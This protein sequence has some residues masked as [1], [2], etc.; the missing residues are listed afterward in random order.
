MNRLERSIDPLTA[1]SDNLRRRMYLY[2]R[3]EGH[4]VSRQEVARAAGVS[5]KLAAFHL[6]KLVEQ[7]LLTYGYRRPPGRTGPGAGRPAKVYEPS[8]MELEVSIPERRYDLMGKLLVDAVRTGGADA[9]PT[10]HA[11]AT[12]RR[13]GLRL[14]ETVRQMRR[15]RPPG[16]ERTLTVVEEVLEEHGF[17]PYR[18]G[19][20]LRL[21]NCPFHSLSGY[22]PDLVCAM[23]HAFIDG[24][25]R[26]IG[27][28]TLQVA[29]EPQPG[30]CCVALRSSGGSVTGCPP[31]RSAQ[32]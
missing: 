13:E 18:Q 30:Q 25:V 2:V 31:C 12:A 4:P 6:D 7:G 19:N 24:V 32:P 1:L 9:S 17:E 27:N 3:G 29:L 16:A 23:N 8:A 15:L 11:V 22:A 21:R 10:Q 26:G 20:E 14:G 28:E 5:P